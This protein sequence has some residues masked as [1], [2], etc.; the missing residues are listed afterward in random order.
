M[1]IIGIDFGTTKTIA[2]ILRDDGPHIIPDTKGRLSMP[3]LVLVTPDEEIFVG[4]DAKSHPRRY[5]SEHITITSIKRGLGRLGENNWG[6][7][8]THPQEVAALILARLKLEVESSLD[9]EVTEAVIA[10]PAHFDINQR[11][12]VMQAAE[13]AGL[14]VRRL[15]NEAT[16]A[17]ISYFRG[18]PKKDGIAIVV[19]IG[20]GT[21]DVSVI[22]YG[23]GVLEV[24][25]TTGA[26]DLGGDDLDQIIIDRINEEI[27][28]RHGQIV[29]LSEAHKLFL[30]EAAISAKVEL[31]SSEQARVRLPGLIKLVDG[32]Y[33]DLDVQLS[34]E[35][36]TKWI[37]PFANRVKE[38]IQKALKDTGMN[39][40][41]L[42]GLLLIGGTSRIP[43]LRETCLRSG[44]Q[45]WPDVDQEYSVAKGAA[46]QAGVLS[47]QANS[48]LLLDSFP[49]SLSVEGL[50]GTAQCLVQRNSTIPTI[51]TET[52]T[53]TQDFQQEITVR[54]FEGERAMAKDNSFLGSVVLSGIP[55]AAKG[56]PQIKV[57]FDIDAN[58]TITVSARDQA[59]THE[60]K[61][62]LSAPFRLNPA[63]VN[64]MRRA[65]SE[66]MKKVAAQLRVEHEM[67]RQRAADAKRGSVEKSLED[68][69][70]G[71]VPEIDGGKQQILKQALNVIRDYGTRDVSGDALETLLS[72]VRKEIDKLLSESV[73]EICRRF[74]NSPEFLPW[75][76][77]AIRTIEEG[78]TINSIM[79]TVKRTFGATIQQMMNCI[80]R[81]DD[82]PYLFLRST[83]ELS[84]EPVPRYL[85][86]LLITHFYPDDRPEIQSLSPMSEV[87]PDA[88]SILLLLLISA[89]DADKPKDRIVSLRLLSTMIEPRMLS[90]LLNRISSYSSEVNNLLERIPNDVWYEAFRAITSEQRSDWLSQKGF[91]RD[92]LR[93]ALQT[94]IL[95][96]QHSEQDQMLDCLAKMGERESVPQLLAYVKTLKDDQSRASIIRSL[97]SYQDPRVV[98]PL[99]YH[100]RN[101]TSLATAS[102]SALE[103]CKDFLDD[104]WKR[105]IGFVADEVNPGLFSIARKGIYFRN[106]VDTHKGMDT[107]LFEQLIN[108]LGSKWLRRITFWFNKN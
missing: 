11:W 10:I 34:R 87:D 71:L 102:N 12:A 94:L 77:A 78:G 47:G 88:R 53:T 56:V 72:G 2:V 69:M 32:T 64:V 84:G 91:R 86:G 40:E 97:P 23:E 13:I 65:V 41:H 19:D 45:L 74:V 48:F 36:F 8:K 98:L 106:F 51:R 42:D 54:V 4:W 1:S 20:G 103:R 52:F 22:Q 39:P 85:F 92:R 58:G 55:P 62:I 17:S 50:G 61:A 7:W 49:N 31:S 60:T 25:S 66:E 104:D 27:G 80:R 30:R 96:K 37:T 18:Q 29:P 57:T 33:E 21:T 107:H 28:K 76:E 99:L 105:L 89:L 15:L 101:Q 16:A 35:E 93:L 95:H 108:S 5:E 44:I 26:N 73:A 9:E 83:Q 3:S 82:L 63:Q 70:S 75:L 59:T 38:L 46:I 14:K 100:I 79:N 43:A 6:R 81:S 24:S 68:L 90:P 67:A